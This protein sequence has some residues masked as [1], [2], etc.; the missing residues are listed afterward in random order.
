VL[1]ALL[2]FTRGRGGVLK[3]EAPHQLDSLPIAARA[4]RRREGDESGAAAFSMEKVVQQWEPWEPHFSPF[5]RNYG[6]F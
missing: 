3:P 6:V 4:A 1:V 5:P 2:R